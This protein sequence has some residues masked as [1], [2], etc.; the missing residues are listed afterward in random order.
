MAQAPSNAGTPK[1]GTAPTGDASTPVVIK[2]YANRRLYNTET[3]SYITLEHL[4]TMTREG[5]DFQVFDARTGEDITRSVLTQIVMEEEAT[6]QTMLPVPFLRQIIAMYG[7]SMQAMVPHYLEASMAA[8]AEN[9]DKFRNAALK[10]FEQLTKQN[11]ALFQA[12]TSMLTAAR[13]TAPKPTPTAAKPA[14]PADAELAQ[15]K[16]QLA[17]LQARLDGMAKG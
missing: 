15:L 17:A 11:L 13:P 6:G 2:K 12:A 8:F 3:S 16:A 1:A 4:A 7:D 10:P 5:R 14:A 9:Q